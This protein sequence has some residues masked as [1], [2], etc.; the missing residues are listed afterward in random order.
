MNFKFSKWYYV[1]IREPLL[2]QEQEEQQEQVQ[3]TPHTNK[4]TYICILKEQLKQ[5]Y[6]K[7]Y[8][9]FYI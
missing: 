3:H 4:Q 9:Y 1:R 2:K 7:S 6:I 5:T 8:I